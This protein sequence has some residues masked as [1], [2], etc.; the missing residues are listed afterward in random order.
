MSVTVKKDILTVEMM[1]VQI[2][3][4]LVLLAHL[5]NQIVVFLVSVFQT[6]Y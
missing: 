3:I 5:H 6:E 1:N 4:N 2:A